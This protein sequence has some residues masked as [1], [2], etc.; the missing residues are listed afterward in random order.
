L[1]IRPAS[2][3][4]ANSSSEKPLPFAGALAVD[5]N[6]AADHQVHRL[7]FG[8]PDPPPGARRTADGGGAAG[9]TP[10]RSGSS[11]MNARSSAR[12]RR[13]GWP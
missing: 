13:Q 9:G 6:A 7:Q 5:R 8:H 4:S 2:T 3:S 10:R 1:P 12:A 11:R